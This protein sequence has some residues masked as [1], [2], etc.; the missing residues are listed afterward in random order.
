[1]TDTLKTPLVLAA[2]VLLALIFITSGWAK[3]VGIEGTAGYITSVGLPAA[4]ALAVGAGAFELAAGLALAVGFQARW[5]ALGL[6]VFT[7]LAS[8]LFHAYW[9]VPADQ[10]VMQKLMFMKNLAIAGGMFFVAVYGA[11]PWSVDARRTRA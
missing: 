2:R 6:G 3:L 5:A 1:M 4:T 11:G 7:L 10:L 9:S 8:L